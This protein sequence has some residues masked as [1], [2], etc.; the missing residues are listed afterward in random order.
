[1]DTIET[2]AK[3][4]VAL[5]AFQPELDR[6]MMHT[7]LYQ[8]TLDPEKLSPSGKYMRFDYDNR[9][10]E[11]ISEIHGWKAIDEIVI[12]EILEEAEEENINEVVNG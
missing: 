3:K 7:V 11:A 2:I 5:V 10:G 12:F 1:M 8:V 4:T 9:E 6:P